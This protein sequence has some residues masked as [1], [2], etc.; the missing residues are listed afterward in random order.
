L[1][2]GVGVPPLHAAVPTLAEVAEVGVDGELGGADAAPQHVRET[3][4]SVSDEIS[5]EPPLS[6]HQEGHDDKPEGQRR[7]RAR[8]HY[9]A[10]A[11]E[12]R[13]VLGLA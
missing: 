8:P 7:H 11:G 4:E 6:R 12:G 9:V 5:K 13:R 2:A 3:Y 10:Q 1:T